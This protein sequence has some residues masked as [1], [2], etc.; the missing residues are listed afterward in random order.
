MSSS[1]NA[2][3]ILAIA[4]R[5]EINGEQFYR[6]AA[7]HAPN[8]PS[9]MILLELASMEAKHGQVFTRMRAQLPPG[10]QEK[11]TFD[12]EGQAA[13]YLQ[14]LADSRIFDPSN[15]AMAALPQ[16]KLPE[17]LLTAIGLEKESIAFYVGLLEVVPPELGRS[18]VAEIV[19]EEMRHVV[20]L[21][22]ELAKV[23]KQPLPR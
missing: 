19:R 21:N 1:F 15:P 13:Q 10:P 9:Q 11:T 8:T 12:P 7:E 2:D 17:V 20:I 18:Y 23:Q 22:E 5:I 4:Q 16:M 3:E 6:K 14:A